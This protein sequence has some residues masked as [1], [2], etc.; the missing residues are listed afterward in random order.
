MNAKNRM[1]A[2]ALGASLLPLATTPPAAAKRPRPSD[3]PGAQTDLTPNGFQLYNDYASPERTYE[4]ERVV[5]HYVVLGVDAPPLNDDDSDEV[6]DYVERV[7]EAADRAL[8]YYE[9]R[10]FHDP[11]GDEGGPNAR[12]DLYVSRFAPGMLGVAFPA[13]AAAGGA[14][15]VVS[16][17]LDPS[18]ARSFASLYATVAHELFHLVQFSYFARDTEP[19]IPTW[20]LEGTASGLETRANPELDDLVTG[21][22]LRRWFS[23][24]QQPITVQSYGAQL[25]WR[26]LDAEQ[27]RLLHALFRRLAARPVAGEGERAVLATYARIAGRPFPPAF[28]RFALSVAADHGDAIEPLFS[29]EPGTT[30]RVQVAPLAVHYVRTVLPRRGAYSLTVRF[31]RG[32]GSASATLAYQFESELAGGRPRL[33]RIAGRRSHDGRTLT[34]AVPAALRAS[35][36]L[37]DP[38]LVVSNGGERSV[39]YEVGARRAS[40]A[41]RLATR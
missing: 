36:R 11:V 27:P 25:L 31:P 6:P 5:V 22:Q 34:F 9:R 17:N 13:A 16:N 4:S 18:A 41:R 28:H 30:R 10:G 32:R 19:S 15:A 37:A 23:A 33:G 12:P 39:A 29:L 2:V 14:F 24:T 35:A 7:G 26:R 21:I 40:S 20:I 8:A 1:A 38:L 3:V